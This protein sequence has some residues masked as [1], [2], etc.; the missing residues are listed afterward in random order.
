MHELMKGIK[1]QVVITT[2]LELIMNS[3][4]EFKVPLS[5]SF[6]YKSVKP[7]VSWITDLGLRV[8]QLDDWAKGTY[9]IIYWISGFTFPT[10]FTTALQQ[11]A[12]ERQ[13]CSIDNLVWDFLV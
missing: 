2:E 11:Q 10:G 9:P 3:F 13:Q 6:A 5:W 4:F 7:L 8:K 12:A 1:G